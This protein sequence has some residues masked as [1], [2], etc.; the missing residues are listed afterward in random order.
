VWNRINK[1]LEAANK[2]AEPAAEDLPSIIVRHPP[3]KKPTPAPAPA[4]APDAATVPAAKQAP[5]PRPVIKLKVGGGAQVKAPEKP[6]P[7]GKPVEAPKAPPK[8]KGRKAKVPDDAPPPYVDDGS[9]DLLQEVIAI[10][11]EK[12]EE[13]RQRK[14][15]PVKE[16]PPAKASSSAPPIK[17]RKPNAEGED[18]ILASVNPISRKDRASVP[19]GS[20]S[21][22][23]KAVPPVP[24]PKKDKVPE[25]TSTPAPATEVPRISLKGKEREVSS[26]QPAP[27]KAR[28]TP[29]ATSLNEK[30]C[31]DVLKAISRLP[32]YPIFAYPVDPVRDGCPT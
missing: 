10:E 17:R 15:E 22:T 9:H 31:R 4:P 16:S 25:R 14:M 13:K 29:S 21:T 12:D 28:A 19:S 30:K 2:A 26:A 5:A 7:V 24:K 32:E 23:P 3:Q 11:R 1:T 8:P 20:S 27:S 6:V 18:G